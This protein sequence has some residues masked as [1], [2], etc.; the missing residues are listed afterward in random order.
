MQKTTIRPKAKE[1]E[2]YRIPGPVQLQCYL[3]KHS[4]LFNFSEI[5]RLCELPSGTLRHICAGSR[6]MDHRQ[7]AKMQEIILPMLT[8]IVFLL[9]N[10]KATQQMTFNNW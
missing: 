7:Y 3:V 8:E 6:D 9:Q 5:E 4:K 2:L 10:Y 1:K